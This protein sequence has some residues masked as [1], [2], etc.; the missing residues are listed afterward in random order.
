MGQTKQLPLSPEGKPDGRDVG[1]HEFRERLKHPAGDIERAFA[2]LWEEE[3]I[4]KTGV[5]HGNGL[6][7]DLFIHT[8]S[9]FGFGGKVVHEITDQERVVVATVIQWLGT[10]CGLAFINRAFHDAGYNMTWRKR[11][12]PVGD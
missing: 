1:Y 3:N 4:A 9:G 8:G 10:N 5:N 12:D 11:D 6:L 2:A 7:Q